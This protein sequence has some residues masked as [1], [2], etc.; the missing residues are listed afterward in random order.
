VK[1]HGPAVGGRKLKVAD[2]EES[3]AAPLGRRSRR[4][5]GRATIADVARLAGVAPI[6]VSRALRAP[7]AVSVELRSRIDAAVAELGY[8]PDP[9]ARAL[10]SSRSD[11]VGVVVPALTNIV[12]NDVLSGIYDELGDST[13]QVQIA[14]THYSP[15]EEERLLR[16]FVNQRPAALIV[17]G[18]D[19]T[20][21]ARALL[22][23]AGCPIVQV[24]ELSE[25]PVDMLVGFSQYDG[26]RAAAAHLIEAGYRRIGFV[27][28]R[29]DPRS[30]RRLAGYQHRLEEVGLY[31][32][33]LVTTTM[34]P[35]SIPLGRQLLAEALRRAPDLDAVFCNNDDLALGVLFECQHAGLRVP[36][37]LGICGFNDLDMMAATWPALTSIAT[38][39][40][41]IGRQAMAMIKA[42]LAGKDVADPV[43]D[44][45]FALQ[46]RGS[47]G[48]SKTAE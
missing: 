32:P 33:Q 21:A 47:T 9:A 29:M 6:T 36:Q 31:D 30:Q 18:I 22:E 43:R 28:A 4:G 39:R 34:T 20:P 10:A 46:I 25:A 3:D 38:P 24:M 41:Q 1:E 8:E 15:L 14:N 37:Q 12:F 40:Y 27:G 16:S 26:G 7:G 19:Q 48:R 44:L 45:G 35:S 17:A 2:R 13:L 5:G 23:S 42:R 11:M